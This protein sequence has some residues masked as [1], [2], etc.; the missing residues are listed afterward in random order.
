[1]GHSHKHVTDHKGRNLLISILLNSVITL[2]QI[3]GGFLSGSLALLSD[4]L[5][6]LTDVI[7]L[8]ISYVASGFSKK[9]ATIS[10]TFGYKRAEIIAWGQINL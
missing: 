1:M 2:A 8:V 5:H 3:I 7:S 4:A 10:R 6:N 9:E